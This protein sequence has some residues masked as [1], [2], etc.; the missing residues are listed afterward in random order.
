MGPCTEGP[1]LRMTALGQERRDGFDGCISCLSDKKYKTGWL[2][3]HLLNSKN[4]WS[5]SYCHILPLNSPTTLWSSLGSQPCD[6]RENR[7]VK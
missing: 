6:T 7:E 4:L 3:L 1:D 2:L 5:T